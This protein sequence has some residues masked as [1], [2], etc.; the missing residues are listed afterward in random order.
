MKPEYSLKL[1]QYSRILPE[2]GS[3]ITGA[4]GVARD[5]NEHEIISIPIGGQASISN[6]L[7]FVLLLCLPSGQLSG[8]AKH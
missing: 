8:T 1:S 7:A 3:E 2:K 6:E 5:E 4:H